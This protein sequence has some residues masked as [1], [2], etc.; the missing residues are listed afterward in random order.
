LAGRTL[1]TLGTGLSALR[2][3]CTFG[4]LGTFSTFGTLF[5]ELLHRPGQAIQTIAKLLGARQLIGEARRF[6]IAI[7][8]GAHLIGD[9]VERA[10]DLIRVIP[11]AGSRLPAPG[12]FPLR[13]CLRRLAHAARNVLAI[14]LSAG[15]GH[16]LLLIRFCAV[17]IRKL[18]HGF[19]ET[20]RPIGQPL[21]F[22]SKPSSRILTGVALRCSRGL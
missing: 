12:L 3:L 1:L 4:T 6:R 19:T 22:C 10:R 21:L 7:A 13:D 17:A 2:G 9:L 16:R 20:L 11:A 15:V 8:G 5:F 14:E 18:F